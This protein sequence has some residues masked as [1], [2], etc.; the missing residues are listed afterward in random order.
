MGKKDVTVNIKANDIQTSKKDGYDIIGAF[1]NITSDEELGNKDNAIKVF[2]GKEGIKAQ[3]LTDSVYI[4]TNDTIAYVDS[5]TA[6]N[7]VHITGLSIYNAT[8]TENFNASI[9]ANR[10]L[11][12]ISCH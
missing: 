3:S 1:V 7:E 9:K 2:T 6:I 11:A 4:L 5:I 12:P 8:S 10:G